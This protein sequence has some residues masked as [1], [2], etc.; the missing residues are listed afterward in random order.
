MHKAI[1]VIQFKIEGQIIRRH[2]E[3]LRLA[4]SDTHRDGDEARTAV[5]LPERVHDSFAYKRL[6]ES[7]QFQLWSPAFQEFV[8]ADKAMRKEEEK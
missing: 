5:I 2:P 4:G 7:R 8:E 3:Y 1:A 6:I